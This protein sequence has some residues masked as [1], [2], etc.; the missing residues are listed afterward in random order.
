MTFRC[1][2]EIG[3]TTVTKNMFAVF[4][5]RVIGVLV[6]S[7]LVAAARKMRVTII[8]IFI[9]RIS[10]LSVSVAK[11]CRAFSVRYQR[12]A[13]RADCNA[14]TIATS[15][16]AAYI[17]A[18]Y[19]EPASIR[20]VVIRIALNEDAASAPVKARHAVVISDVDWAIF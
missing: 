6:L 17:R 3:M 10:V 15:G 13:R 14:T 5:D 18:V 1:E 8:V 11:D 7:L 20:C 2:E 4:I 19:K 16:I 9:V 12:L